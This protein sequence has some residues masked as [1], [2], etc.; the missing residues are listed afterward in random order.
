MQTPGAEGYRDAGNGVV[1]SL[2]ELRIWVLPSGGGV[3]AI[4]VSV[5]GWDA[6]AAGTEVG[7]ARGPWR[8]YVWSAATIGWCSRGSGLGPRSHW[9]ALA[10]RGVVSCRVGGD[11][12]LASLARWVGWRLWQLGFN[13]LGVWGRI[14]SGMVVKE[15]GCS[16][17]GL[18]ITW[19]P[20]WS[21]GYLD[22]GLL[23]V[24]LLQLA[25]SCSPRLL[26]PGRGDH[27]VGT[28]SWGFWGSLDGPWLTLYSCGWDK[29]GLA[30]E[31][32]P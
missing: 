18:R 23:T 24:G 11:S 21:S 10:P 22:L 14:W 13:E 3:S 25:S 12:S 26:P 30:G 28:P 31:L 16:C 29:R 32:A 27:S 19:G 5:A 6:A 7:L 9:P 1:V 2:D 20:A 17:R 4:V 15:A 8:I